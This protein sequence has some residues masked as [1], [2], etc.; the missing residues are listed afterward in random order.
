MDK[1]HI[2]TAAELMNDD[3]RPAGD[4]KLEP[5]VEQAKGAED[6]KETRSPAELHADGPM[7]RWA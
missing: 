2:K 6:I 7:G 5:P 4:S 3:K 1:E